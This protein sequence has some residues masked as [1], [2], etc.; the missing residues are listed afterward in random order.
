[1]DD[2]IQEVTALNQFILS[3]VH[4]AIQTALNKALVK[5][6]FQPYQKSATPMVRS[7]SFFGGWRQL[8]SS[9]D[10]IKQTWEW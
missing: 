6:V 9:Y 10:T 1:M 7:A 5:A 2:I 8:I 4:I 3:K